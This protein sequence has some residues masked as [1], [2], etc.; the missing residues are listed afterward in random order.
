M[1]RGATATIS[2]PAAASLSQ[3]R[4]HIM[5]PTTEA[6]RGIEAVQPISP[7]RGAIAA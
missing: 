5:A 7:I 2:I 6:I 1:N 4:A 3:T